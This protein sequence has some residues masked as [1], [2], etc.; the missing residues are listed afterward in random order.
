MPKGY[1]K[2][3]TK[4]IPPSNRGLKF[5][6]DHKKKIG[7]AHKGIKYIRRKSFLKYRGTKHPNQA[8]EKHWNCQGGITDIN[9]KIRNSIEYKLWRETVFKRDNYTCIWCGQRGGG[10]LHADHIKP[11]AQFPELRFAI[12]NGRTLC[13]KCH[14][15]TFTYLRNKKII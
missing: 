4:I 6:D 7:L 13:V 10:E 12:D 8:A 11:F 1:R 9:K 2:N 3:G 14:R 5:S 15:T